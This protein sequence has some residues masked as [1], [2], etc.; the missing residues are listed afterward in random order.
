MPTFPSF[1]PRSLFYSFSFQGVRGFH[2]YFSPS[3]VVDL[4]TERVSCELV[5]FCNVRMEASGEYS[6]RPVPVCAIG[7]CVSVSF[8]L[9]IGLC[10]FVLPRVAPRGVFLTLAAPGDLPAMAAISFSFSGIVTR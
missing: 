8:V 7:D 2:A 1:F 10:F 5:S 4:W 3:H 6:P 9:I